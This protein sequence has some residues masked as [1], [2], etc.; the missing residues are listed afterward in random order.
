MRLDFLRKKEEVKKDKVG[1]V[2]EGGGLRGIFSGGVNDCLLDNDI[3][4]DYVIGVSAGSGNLYE[5]VA[6]KRGYIKDCLIQKNRLDS[7][8]GFPQMI[9]SHKYINLDKMYD[10]YADKY[11]FSYE[12]FMTNPI[13]WEVVVSN[14][15]TGEAEY[16]HT[17]DI[18]RSKLIGKASCSIPGFVPPVKIDDQLYLDGGICDSIPVQRA[19]DKGCD[20]VIVVLTRKKGNFSVLKEPTRTLMKQ[21]YSDY[22]KF[23]D[24]ML[25][26]NDLYKNQVALAEQLEEEGKAIIIRPTMQEVGRLESNEDELT[27][28]YY[29]GYTKAKEYIDTIKSWL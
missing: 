20:K 9:E 19:L 6:K 16:M 2:F 3:N 13:E 23:V 11:G 27:L 5:Y 29:H 15:E 7:F 4:V 17:N 22:P 25:A 21:M 14:I 26:R 12:N 28:A 1:L 8:Y 24:A 18:E 10:E